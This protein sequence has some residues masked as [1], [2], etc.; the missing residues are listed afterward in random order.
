MFLYIHCGVIYNK[1]SQFGS[2][3]VPNSV[4]CVRIW[5]KICDMQMML[6]FL[7]TNTFLSHFADDF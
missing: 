2:I 7:K 3:F 1:A 5:N 6:E 4:F